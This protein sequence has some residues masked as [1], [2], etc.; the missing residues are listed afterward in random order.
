M[1][2]SLS[3]PSAEWIGFLRNYGPIPCN[4]N[5]YDET[6]QRASKRKKIEPPTFE[7]AY[8]N[9]LIENFQAAIPKSVILTG[10]AGDGKTYY[11]RQVWEVLCGSSLY[12]NSINC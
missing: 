9:E 12:Q 1:A 2:Q 5:M 7:T 11:C 4:D 8:L 10:T 3:Y 6:I